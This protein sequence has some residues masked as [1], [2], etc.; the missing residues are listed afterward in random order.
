[1]IKGNPGFF[2]VESTIREVYVEKSLMALGSYIIHVA[3]KAYGVSSPDAS[4]LACSFDAVNLR[5]RRRGQHVAS[6]DCDSAVDIMTKYLKTYYDDFDATVISEVR[7]YDE[8]R[9]QIQSAGIIL[10]PD[11]DAAF[12]DGSHIL[13]FDIG[14]RIRIVAFKNEAGLDGRLQSL[15]DV[16]MDAHIFYSTLEEWR[17]CFIEERAAKLEAKR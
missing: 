5:I 7:P 1:M 4:I 12:D 15:T 6:F 11:G 9:M 10:A 8:F 3:G 13:Q 16:S 2:A 14:D 17:Q